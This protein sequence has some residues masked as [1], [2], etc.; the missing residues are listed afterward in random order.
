M[1]QKF[2]RKREISG[3]VVATVSSGVRVDIDIRHK[4]EGS[5]RDGSKFVPVAHRRKADVT[6]Q[7]RSSDFERRDLAVA[8][9]HNLA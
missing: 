7:P 2:R 5:W 4:A 6:D 3:A 8:E 9:R 1:P